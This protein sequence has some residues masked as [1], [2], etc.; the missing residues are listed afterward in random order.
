MKF[1][2]NM[3][4]NYAAPLSASKDKRCKN[5]IVMVSDALKELGLSQD[6]RGIH[7]LFEDTYSYAVNMANSSGTRK[8]KIFAQGSY[9]N[10]TNVRTE[11]DVDIAVIQEEVFRTKY[12]TNGTYVQTDADY[13]FSVAE[14][15]DKSFKD[16]VL[17]C[18]RGKFG[19]DVERKNKSIKIHGNSYRNDA[20][21]VPCMRYRDYTNDFRKD[22]SNYV[23]GIVIIPDRGDS[24]INYPEQHI[25]NGRRKNQQTNHFYKKMVRVMKKLRYIMEDCGYEA[26]KM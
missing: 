10:N 1:N 15:K 16:E 14:K 2:E 12:R 19:S 7:K 18:L 13:R 22:E 26:L 9:A 24:I 23:G 20:D 11:S 8:V 21:A 6:Q 17:S 5:A 4:N 25:E 3:L